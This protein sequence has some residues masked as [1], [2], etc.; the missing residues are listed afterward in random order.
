[1]A[2][3][4]T[5]LPA[6]PTASTSPA[7]SL[8]RIRCLGRR[9][10]ETMRLRSETARPLRRLAS[11]VWTSNRLTVAA[12]ILRRTSSSLGTGRSTSSS[13][14]TSGGPYLSWTTALMGFR[15]FCVQDFHDVGAR[16]PA[17]RDER[18]RD[19]HSHTEQRDQ[20]QLVPIENRVRD[21]RGLVAGRVAD[22]V[23]QDV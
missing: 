3:T 2:P 5:S 17:A 10:P 12:W 23:V 20:H 6:A 15:S 7:N 9:R 19:R 14:R 13:R 22:H 16:G 21:R 1:A 11:R 4:A 8:P 18:R